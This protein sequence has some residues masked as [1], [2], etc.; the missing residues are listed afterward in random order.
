MIVGAK[1]TGPVK[2]DLRV[3]G[4][5]VNADNRLPVEGPLT[6]AEL[7]ATQVEVRDDYDED[8]PLEDQAGSNAVLTFNFS[9]PVNMIVVVSKGANLTSRASVY[10][11][12]SATKGWVCDDG[13][14]TYIPVRGR[15]SVKVYAPQGA[16]V[17]VVGMRRV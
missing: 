5:E 11:T 4:T 8:E 3:E 7:G 10:D 9:A 13:V 15:A 1:I 17:S 16:T 14:P 6:A 2:A 12:P